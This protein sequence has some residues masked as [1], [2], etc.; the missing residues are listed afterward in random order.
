MWVIFDHRGGYFK[1][2]S[3]L[4]MESVGSVPTC[5]SDGAKASQLTF[6]ELFSA[7]C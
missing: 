2:S 1:L 3:W 6:H 4:G 5:F 7:V